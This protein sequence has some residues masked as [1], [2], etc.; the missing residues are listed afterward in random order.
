MQRHYFPHIENYHRKQQ[1]L[2]PLP[3]PEREPDPE[4]EAFW[5]HYLEAHGKNDPQMIQENT[6]WWHR[7]RWERYSIPLWV[8]LGGL[9]FY[10][11][12]RDHSGARTVY[13]YRTRRFRLIS[14]GSVCIINI[15]EASEQR[16]AMKPRI[17]LAGK[18]HYYDWRN[19]LVPNLRDLLY[20]DHVTEF[21]DSSGYPDHDV[22]DWV[23]VGPYPLSC[24]G[25]SARQK[26]QR[27]SFEAIDR[28]DIVF[29]NLERGE[30]AYGTIAELGYAHARGKDIAIHIPHGHRLDDLWFA[31]LLKNYGP[32]MPLEEHTLKDHFSAVVYH[33]QT[34]HQP[35]EAYLDACAKLSV[36]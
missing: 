30:S 22:G 1:G 8:G 20:D 29:A 32:E 23:F 2:N 36:A 18:I 14:V 6:E 15:S 10:S 25:E 16:S 34:T 28:A 26:V 17:Y 31:Y 33:W 11:K 27:W 7:M 35:V 4:F 5:E 12:A 9:R 13:E 21:L 19:E 24:E 3:I